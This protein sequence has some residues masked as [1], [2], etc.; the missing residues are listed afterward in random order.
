MILWNLTFCVGLL[1]KN[2]SLKSKYSTFR[3]VVDSQNMLY[4]QSESPVWCWWWDAMLCTA[5]DVLEPADMGPTD[6]GACGWLWTH[7]ENYCW[8]G[9]RAV[10]I[11]QSIGSNYSTFSAFDICSSQKRAN[12]LLLPNPN[13]C[14]VWSLSWVWTKF[15]KKK[16]FKAPHI[17]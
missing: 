1:L 6:M 11:N 3:N 5:S 12:K 9:P 16:T 14:E 2:F 4:P 15:Q 8:C 17:P 7:L 13:N 10:T